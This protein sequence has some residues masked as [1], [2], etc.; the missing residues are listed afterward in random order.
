MPPSNKKQVIKEK[1]ENAP[2]KPE[3]LQ[4]LR[5]ESENRFRHRQLRRQIVEDYRRLHSKNQMPDPKSIQSFLVRYMDNID[6]VREA[7]QPEKQAGDPWGEEIWR[8]LKS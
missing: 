2:P 4:Q 1:K 7:L 5:I 6:F 3:V 8:L